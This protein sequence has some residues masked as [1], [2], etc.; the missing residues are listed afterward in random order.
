MDTEGHQGRNSG[1]NLEAGT[2][3][4]TV[5]NYCLLLCFPGLV[6]SAFLYSPGPPLQSDTAQGLV[7]SYQSLIK[8]VLIGQSDG[9]SS[10]IECPSSW[11]TLICEIDLKKK[12]NYAVNLN[13][14]KRFIPIF[15]TDY[16]IFRY[17]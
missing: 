11:V 7:F 9:D 17:L 3:A 8:K 13:L 2:D 4:E 1:S 10:L 6:Q 12:T 5:E 16:Y 15:F 14:Y